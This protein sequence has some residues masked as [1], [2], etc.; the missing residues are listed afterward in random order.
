M[1]HVRLA[2]AVR[3]G[4]KQPYAIADDHE[5]QV[6][7]ALAVRRGLKPVPFANVP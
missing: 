2:L 4:L 3:R 6:R 5:D 1:Q 7:L